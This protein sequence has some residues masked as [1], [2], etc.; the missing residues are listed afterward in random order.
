MKSSQAMTVSKMKVLILLLQVCAFVAPAFAQSWSPASSPFPSIDWLHAGVG[1]IPARTQICAK[2]S[3]PAT[4]VEINAALRACGEGKTVLLADGKYSI[5]RE[6]VVP[7]HVTLRGEGANRTILNA[8]G[9]SEAVIRMGAGDVAYHPVAITAN[10]DAGSKEIALG[11]TGSIGVG[12]LLVISENNLPGLVT[13]QGSE[14]SCNWCDGGWTRDGHMARGQIVQV[15]AIHGQRVSIDPPLYVNYTQQPVAVPF[16]PVTQYA[17][18]EDLQVYANNSGYSVNITMRQCA[19]CWVKGVESNYADGDHLHIRWGFHDEVRDS[20]LSNAYK[21]LPGK[22]SNLQI[23]LKTS[24][25]LVENN[26]IERTHQSIMPV[27]GAAGNVI[28][29]N[30]MTGD[31]DENAKDVL[32]GGIDFHGAHPQFNLM[33][34]NVLASIYEDSVWGSTSHNVAFRNWITGANRICSPLMGRGSSDCKG[35]NQRMSFQA[36]RAVQVSYLATQNSFIGNVVGSAMMKTLTAYGH[37]LPIAAIVEYPSKRSYDT[38]AYV[39]NFGYG[40]AYDD[41]SGTG[42]AGAPGQCHL[43]HLISKNYLH[44]NYT[45]IAGTVQWQASQAHSLPPSLYLHAKPGWWKGVPYPSIGPDVIG[46][47]DAGGHS[48]GN[49]ARSCFLNVLHG[50]EGG[51]GLPV[52]F[53]ASAC[54]GGRQ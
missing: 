9:R 29:Y 1:K 22:D 42:C 7:S 2:L 39:W 20:Y 24:A 4:D 43:P 51:S 23:M 41:A 46:G 36:V 54:F 48:Y 34:G 13:S 17:G 19:Y 11:N 5:N 6:I 12:S 40:E 14:G 8:L 31:F 28:A 18:V 3:P 38:S 21:H 53:N 47:I 49:P 10:A 30:Y 15:T 37:P 45:D 50:S 35:S 44:G 16:S 33:E 26:I 27:W 25:S 32:I 52:S